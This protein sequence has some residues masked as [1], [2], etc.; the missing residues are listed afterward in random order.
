M[1]DD[2]SSND[3]DDIEYKPFPRREEQLESIEPIKRQ[4]IEP[5]IL[6][7][8]VLN[9][10][11]KFDKDKQVE[12]LIEELK[13]PNTN[14]P[15]GSNGQHVSTLRQYAL[16]ST[17]DAIDMSN[18]SVRLIYQPNLFT[19]RNDA[20]GPWNFNYLLTL[21]ALDYQ[22]DQSGQSQFPLVWK[23]CS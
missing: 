9:I 19:R 21:L 13:K 15:K 3:D 22:Y 12:A 7:E 14:I 4:S 5:V 10:Y 16:E 20:F 23:T 11:I 17:C 18:Q 1:L 2:E 8:I 6:N